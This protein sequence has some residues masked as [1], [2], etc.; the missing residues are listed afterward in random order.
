M[1]SNTSTRLFSTR[2]EDFLHHAVALGE[3]SGIAAL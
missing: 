2:G 3:W 1:F